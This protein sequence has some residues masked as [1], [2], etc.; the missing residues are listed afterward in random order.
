MRHDDDMD[1]RERRR[2]RSSGKRGC[3]ILILMLLLWACLGAG[4]AGAFYFNQRLTDSKFENNS[5]SNQ[6]AAA[7][8]EVAKLKKESSEAAQSF[9][10]EKAALKDTHITVKKHLEAIEATKKECEKTQVATLQKLSAQHE[11]SLTQVQQ[12]LTETESALQQAQEQAQAQENK[13][14]TAEEAREQAIKKSNEATTALKEKEAQIKKLEDSLLSAKSELADSKDALNRL[15]EEL[16]AATAATP[17][18]TPEEPQPIATEQAPAP[19]PTTDTI[20]RKN[21]GNTRPADFVCKITHIDYE[22]DFL[23]LNAG[24]NSGIVEGEKLSVVRDGYKVCDLKI[25]KIT[26]TEAVAVIL[27]DTMLLGE[28]VK[29]NDAVMNPRR[30]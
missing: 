4:V 19:T 25:T 27:K 3:A 5:L 23:I 16:Q 29:V 26:P 1:Y 8:S 24:A 17:P 20:N 22:R 21:K 2:E 6:L 11:S 15:Q 14:R 18:E 30:Y 10:K 28:Q 7:Q 9:K 12:K 13:L